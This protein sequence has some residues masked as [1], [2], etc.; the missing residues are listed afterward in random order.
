MSKIILDILIFRI[1]FKMLQSHHVTELQV[2]QSNI[3][4]DYHKYCWKSEKTHT[5]KVL[6]LLFCFFPVML[7]TDLETLLYKM[8][9]QIPSILKLRH[10]ILG[11][12]SPPHSVIW[13]KKEKTWRI[14]REASYE[15]SIEIA[16]ITSNH[17][18]L[19]SLRY[20]G[21]PIC[22]GNISWVFS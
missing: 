11:P 22:K 5:I 18:S 10:I 15:P 21:P 1:E 6:L 14:V 13:W 7:Y 3:Q 9:V 12:R 17:I 8:R 20:I 19:A 4:I 2:L 16:F